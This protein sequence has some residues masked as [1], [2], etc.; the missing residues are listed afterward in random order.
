M[1]E[2]NQVLE[3]IR[4]R[5]SIR[6]YTDAPLRKEDVL[7]ILEAGRWA[8]SGRN[9]QA[10]RFLVLRA[11][12][13]RADALSRCTKYARI[14]KNATVLICLFLEKTRMY[15]AKKDHQ[16]AGACMQ[17]MLLAAHSLGL[18]ALWIGEII[19]QS[20]QAMDILRLDQEKLE[21]QALL[22]LGYP[23]EAGDADRLPLEKLL[24]EQLWQD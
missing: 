24:L 7:R 20:P 13:P 22:T 21:F 10:W 9:N 17:N 15:D 18:G 8:P 1:A 14:V 12:D 19:N 11:D 23:A 3:A 4:S 2:H 6:R 16:G 5:R